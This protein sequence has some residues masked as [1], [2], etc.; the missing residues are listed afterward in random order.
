MATRDWI[1][2]ADLLEAARSLSPSY[3]KGT[4]SFWRKRGLLPHATRVEGRWAY[5]RHAIEQFA[6]IHRWRVRGVRDIEVTTVALWIEGFEI[7]VTEVRRLLQLF[8]TSWFEQM[9]SIVGGADDPTVAAAALEEISKQ[10]ASKRSRSPL[11]EPM[12]KRRMPKRE[13]EDALTFALLSLAG[14]A[15]EVGARAGSAAALDR[16]MGFDRRRKALAPFLAAEDPMFLA[17]MA[18]PAIL[19]A[20]AYEADADELE[21]A[22]L[23]LEITLRYGEAFAALIA[24]DLGPGFVQM[25]EMMRSTPPRAIGGLIGFGLCSLAGSAHAHRQE[26]DLHEALSLVGDPD[27]LYDL[28]GELEKASEQVIFRNNLRPEDRRQLEQRLR[29]EGLLPQPGRLLARKRS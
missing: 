13:R 12:R 6:A 20:G 8:V 25:I 21:Y 10:M 18:D 26:F 22:R 28:H 4:L 2:P 23:L 11:P 9:E 14:F 17:R 1:S 3:S 29:A 7:P 16:L 19:A 15:S 27:L 24:A 5:P